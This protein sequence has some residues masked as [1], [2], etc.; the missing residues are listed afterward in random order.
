M[1]KVEKRLPYGLM[2][3]WGTVYKPC[4]YV[5]EVDEYIEYNKLQYVAMDMQVQF[6]NM[7]QIKTGKVRNR[8]ALTSD[9]MANNQ[10]DKIETSDAYYDYKEEDFKCV[11][12]VGDIVKLGNEWWSVSEIN[13]NDLFVPKK[14][15]IYVLSV[16]EIG[17]ECINVKN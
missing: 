12:S 6:R 2:V 13:E 15:T 4:E 1:I 11:V 3:E 8:Q 7:N 14:H 9:L 5:E 16:Q 10:E 17:R